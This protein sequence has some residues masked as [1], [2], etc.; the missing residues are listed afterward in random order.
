MKK[1]IFLAALACATTVSAKE[2]FLVA[3]GAS[4]AQ[5]AI[6][7][8]VMS[9]GAAVAV[10]VT[11]QV[12]AKYVDKV[13]FGCGRGA[14]K[15]H[16]VSCAVTKDGRVT[17]IAFSGSNDYLPNGVVSLG[18]ISVPAAANFKVTEF[19]ASDRNAQPIEV[20]IVDGAQK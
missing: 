12:D 13:A 4:K 9:S 11:G 6:A 15:T 8:D 18:T 7:I 5:S 20:S 17:M 3:S 10:Q 19:L 16:Q 2:Q 1:L 14:P